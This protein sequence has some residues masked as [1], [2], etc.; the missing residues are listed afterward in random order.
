MICLNMI[1]KNEAPNIIGTLENL[2]SVVPVSFW[3]IHDTGSSDATPT[4]IQN[5]F[6]QRDVPGRLVHEPW[7][8]FGVNRQKA[9]EDAEGT[10]DFVM[11]FDADCQIS[12]EFP[13]LDLSVDSY[14]IPSVRGSL[15][16]NVK[17][18]VRNDGRYRWRGVVHEALYYKKPGKERREILSGLKVIN[19]SAGARSRDTSTN[20][21]DAVLLSD[22]FRNVPDEDR[23]LLPRYAFYAANSWRDARCPH[24]AVEWYKKRIE[25]GGWKD[26]VYLSHLHMG[27]ELNKTGKANEAI[28]AWRDGMEICPERAECCYHVARLE[29]ERGRNNLALIYAREAASKPYPSGSRLFVWRTVYQF[30]AHFE[31]LWALKNLGRLDEGKAHL[32]ALR[33]AGAPEH[34]Y[35]ILEV[36]GS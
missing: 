24:E 7:V 11:F 19:N 36:S 34:L 29:R 3:V 6:M 23:D 12:G 30:W 15:S 32:E 5:F 25:L 1:V 28:A 22:A 26:E 20:Y 33:A 35:K 8:N 31:V 4:L 16:Y 21:Q 17:H 14:D 9:L 10:A 13:K 18:I 27:I 2:M